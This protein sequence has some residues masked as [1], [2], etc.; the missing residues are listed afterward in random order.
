LVSLNVTFDKNQVG[1]NEPFNV[2]CDLD[3][4]QAHGGR[5]KKVDIIVQQTIW[6]SLSNG[7]SWI[8]SYPLIKSALPGMAAGEKSEQKFVATIDFS[9]AQDPHIPKKLRSELG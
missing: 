8:F 7:Y 1:S 4:T 3:L 2:G 6:L 9:Q 5:I